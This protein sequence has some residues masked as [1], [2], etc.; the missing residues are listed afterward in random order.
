MQCGRRG[1]LPSETAPLLS[2]LSSSAL[3]IST[4]RMGG[5]VSDTSHGPQELFR[6][7]GG[8]VRARGFAAARTGDERLARQ[9]RRNVDPAVGDWLAVLVAGIL[10]LLGFSA[11]RR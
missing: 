7:G 2:L 10:A 8:G 3:P 4:V 1:S 5:A 11:A 9:H 6:L